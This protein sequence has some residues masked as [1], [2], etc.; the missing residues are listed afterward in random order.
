MCDMEI[1]L[2]MDKAI[3]DEYKG[4]EVNDKRVYSL[5]FLRINC[6]EKDT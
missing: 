3:G 6:I 1:I 5:I 2:K 4:I